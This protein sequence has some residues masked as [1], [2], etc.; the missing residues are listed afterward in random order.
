MLGKERLLS[1]EEE[2]EEHTEEHTED[3]T[4]E[5]EESEEEEKYILV[6]NV[7]EEKL[8]GNSGAGNGPG[9]T[10]DKKKFHRSIM[11]LMTVVIEGVPGVLHP[12]RDLRNRELQKTHGNQDAAAQNVATRV[13]G[14]F[15]TDAAS[16]VMSMIPFVG[17]PSSLGYALWLRARRVCLICEIYG[18]DAKAHVGDILSW[19]AIGKGSTTDTLEM[20]VGIV[21]SV[22]AGGVVGFLPVGFLVRKLSTVDK[23]V[24]H[25]SLQAFKHNR[26]EIPESEWSA[27]VTLFAGDI[28]AKRVAKA[29]KRA[30]AGAETKFP[31]SCE[32]ART[33]AAYSGAQAEKARKA[34]AK[35][36]AAVSATITTAYNEHHVGERLGFKAAKPTVEKVVVPAPRDPKLLYTEVFFSADKETGGLGTGIFDVDQEVKDYI[37]AEL[38][39]L[40]NSL[41]ITLTGVVFKRRGQHGDFFHMAQE[42]LQTGKPPRRLL[43]FND[44]IEDHLTAKRGGGNATVRMFNEFGTHKQFPLSAGICTG[45]LGSRGYKALTPEA[46]AT[47]DDNIKSIGRILRLPIP[48]EKK[49]ISAE[50]SK[51]IASLKDMGCGVDKGKNQDAYLL[52]VL[53]RHNFDVIQSLEAIL[54]E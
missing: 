14:N 23:R 34:A 31:K 46:K 12:I 13:E 2:T 42:T 47:I 9:E 3:D 19:A 11:K 18:H 51:K 37:V 6:Y 53:E 7:V 15:Y 17:M 26:T 54:N 52:S 8:E 10:V 45:S 22:L 20:T 49:Q 5:D 30:V 32:R 33:A 28:A 27:A 36:A 48:P 1:L 43:I 21:W 25:D 44:N 4:E 39:R 40:T 50:V 29:T 41:G 24:A 35:K 16:L 38:R